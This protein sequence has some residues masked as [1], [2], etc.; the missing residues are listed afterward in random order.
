MTVIKKHSNSSRSV[1]NAV[2]EEMTGKAYAGVHG[3]AE[4]EIRKTR[5][6]NDIMNRCEEF[7]YSKEEGI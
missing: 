1:K 5:S 2:D 3:N 6:R 7:Q 4:E